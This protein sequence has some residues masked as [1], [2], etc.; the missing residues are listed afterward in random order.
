MS[1]GREP[2]YPRTRDR[3]SGCFGG[4]TTVS[5]RRAH[6]SSD[7]PTIGVSRF[8]GGR[9]PSETGNEQAA[10]SPRRDRPGKYRVPIRIVRGSRNERRFGRLFRG[11]YRN[12][13]MNRDP[14]W[15]ANPTIRVRTNNAMLIVRRRIVTA[16]IARGASAF[17]SR[18]SKPNCRKMKGE[19]TH[20]KVIIAAISQWDLVEIDDY[21]P[22]RRQF[23][24]IRHTS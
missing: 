17:E 6:A 8:W 13:A 4:V 3:L 14:P 22:S 20:T 24:R 15:M 12:P 2:S 10:V 23:T 21:G 11:P 19:S 1:D 16:V 5:R 9:E 7:P 18:K